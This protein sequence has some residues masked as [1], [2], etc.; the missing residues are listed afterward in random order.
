SSPLPSSPLRCPLLSSAPL[1]SSFLS[2]PLSS[3]PPPPSIP[4]L[5]P[6]LPPS[7]PSSLSPPPSHLPPPPPPPPPSLPP[8]SPPLLSSST[9]LLLRKID[10]HTVKMSTKIYCSP[11][12]STDAMDWQILHNFCNRCLVVFGVGDKTT[13]FSL[14]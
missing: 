2:P 8:L 10:V 5:P 9:L 6:S 3:S 1:S 7:L 14:I 11:M 4:F 13:I 12:Y